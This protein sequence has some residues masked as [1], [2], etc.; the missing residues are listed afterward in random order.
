MRIILCEAVILL[1]DEQFGENINEPCK[2]LL[3]RDAYFECKTADGIVLE[4]HNLHMENKILVKAN[5][6]IYKVFQVPEN[7]SEI[8]SNPYYYSYVRLRNWIEEVKPS[9]ENI[10]MWLKF[11]E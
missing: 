4:L 2:N 8:L 9:P 3:S 5:E 10:S 1:I 7:F 6:R 11:E